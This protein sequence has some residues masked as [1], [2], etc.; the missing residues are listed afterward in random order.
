MTTLKEEIK[1]LA[2][3]QAELKNQR[4]TVKFEGVRKYT[5]YEAWSKH[6]QNRCKLRD[7]NV[8]QGLLRGKA[9]EEIEPTAKDPFSAKYCERLKEIYG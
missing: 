9:Y 5:P 1:K 8:A 6:Q 2:G 7:M 4:K 3:E